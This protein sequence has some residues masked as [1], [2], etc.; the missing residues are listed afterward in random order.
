LAVGIPVWKLRRDGR[1]FCFFGRG[2]GNVAAL[3]KLNSAILQS[4]FS[5]L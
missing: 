5:E 1:D 3:A 2:C 4:P